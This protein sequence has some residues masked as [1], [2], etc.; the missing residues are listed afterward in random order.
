L[1]LGVVWKKGMIT[2]DQ[3]IDR[4]DQS[5]GSAPVLLGTRGQPLHGRMQ[6][7]SMYDRKIT[8]TSPIYWCAVK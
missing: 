8:D 4:T 7:H 2:K 5:I 1:I 3:I 6:A